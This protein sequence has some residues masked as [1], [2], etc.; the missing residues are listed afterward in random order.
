MVDPDA[1]NS[2]PRNIPFALKGTLSKDIVYKEALS[3]FSSLESIEHSLRA[4]EETNFLA[5]E[6]CELTALPMKPGS[7]S[8][9]TTKMLELT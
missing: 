9:V 1:K 4:I 6:I 2:I 8:S 5:Q 3:T 7:F